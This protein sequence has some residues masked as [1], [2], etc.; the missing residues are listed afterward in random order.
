MEN[1]TSSGRSHN[2]VLTIST[3]YA[4]RGATSKPAVGGNRYMG[5]TPTAGARYG[6]GI[7][8]KRLSTPL[9][10]SSRDREVVDLILRESRI[11]RSG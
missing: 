3:G 10:E 2:A 7:R 6:T 5:K 8:E 1:Q 9:R 4:R 11:G